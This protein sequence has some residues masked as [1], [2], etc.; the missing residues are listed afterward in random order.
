MLYMFQAATPPNSKSTKTVY[1]ASGTLLKL[2]CYLPLGWKRW[3]ATSTTVVGSSK[4]L[5]K[6]LMLY[7]QFLSTR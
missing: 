5:T 3:N 1:T 2:Y 7:E 6:Y 4:G